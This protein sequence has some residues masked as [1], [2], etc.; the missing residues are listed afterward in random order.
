M[1]NN[2]DDSPIGGLSNTAAGGKCTPSSNDSLAS[3]GH[4]RNSKQH[5]INSQFQLLGEDLQKI[6]QSSHH[7]ELRR[8]DMMDDDELD[9]SSFGAVRRY[10]RDLLYPALEESFRSQR[11]FGI[12]LMEDC[13][14]YTQQVSSA[15]GGQTQIPPPSSTSSRVSDTSGM[16]ESM[17]STSMTMEGV[18][19]AARLSHSSTL[20][21]IS[22]NT[23]NSTDS[24][25]LS[26]YLTALQS[27]QQT[28][29]GRQSDDPAS[30]KIR[31]RW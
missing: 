23:R 3:P 6:R 11:S 7:P 16:T 15:S 31:R 2:L 8:E 22:S 14:I 1:N 19:S 17:L 21:S 20:S 26:D 28:N 30:E 4:Q 25:Q 29:Y 10:V 24:R 27:V 18:S 5:A 12:D 13:D 9:V